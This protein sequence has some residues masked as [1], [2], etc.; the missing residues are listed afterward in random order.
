LREALKGCG[1]VER[2]S[3]RVALRQVR[4]RELVA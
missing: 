4:P 2:I 1:D 3:A